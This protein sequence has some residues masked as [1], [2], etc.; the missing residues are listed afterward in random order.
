MEMDDICQLQHRTGISR[1]FTYM[2][3][4]KRPAILAIFGLLILITAFTRNDKYFKIAQSL[5]IFST[6]YKEVFTYYVEDVNP[7]KLMQTSID[8]MLES[9]DPFTNYISED[10]IEDY[11]TL[12]TGEYGGIGASTIRI[13]GDTYVSMIF[14]GYPAHASDLMIGDM[15]IGVNQVDITNKTNAEISKLMKGQNESEVVLTVKRYGMDAP[16]DIP[17]EREKITID[18]VPYSGMLDDNTGYIKLNEFTS[19]AAENVK[20]AVVALR[21]EGAEDFVLDLRSNP[22]GLLL[23][24]VN[25]C[26]IFMPKNTLIVKTKGK[27]EE[28]N[29]DYFSRFGATATESSL[30]VLINSQSASASEI[31]AGAVQ[32]YDRGVIIGHKSYGKGL[33]QQTRRLSYNA[34]L[35]VTT[36]KYYIPSGRLIQALDYSNRKPDGSVGKVPDSLITSYETRNGRTVYDGGGIDPDIDIDVNQ[37]PLVVRELRNKGFI[38]LFATEYRFTHDQIS[39]PAEFKLSDQEYHQFITWVEANNFSYQTDA[40]IAIKKLKESASTAGNLKEIDK[41]VKR[42]EKFIEEQKSRDLLTFKEQI[43]QLLEMDIISRY[44][45]EK[46]AIEANLA[47]DPVVLE[48]LAVLNDPPRYNEILQ[49]N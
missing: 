4:R 47:H 32:D 20:Q 31:V 24:A 13:D 48:S 9:L 12:N 41:Q 42:L 1:K 45:M 15:L 17:V 30:V 44:Y 43:S 23:E 6:L 22:G 8:A 38:F 10:R 18:N 2:L 37:Y 25:L 7:N 46:G 19:N 40:E 27:I 26:N 11:R 14:E 28:N 16:L 5:S 34:Q 39:G 29:T 36:A 35:K 21:K 3:K 49:L 33:V